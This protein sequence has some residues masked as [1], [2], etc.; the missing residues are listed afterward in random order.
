MQIYLPYKN[1]TQSIKVL[2][3]DDLIKQRENLEEMLSLIL[4]EMELITIN[5]SKKEYEKFLSI[6]ENPLFVYWW[7]QGKPFCSYLLKYLEGCNF[8]LFN[9]GKIYKKY[10]LFKKIIKDNKTKFNNARPQ[11]PKRL[12]DGYRVILLCVREDYYLNKFNKTYRT[13][14]TTIK[15]L[16]ENEERFKFA[17]FLKLEKGV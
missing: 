3:E 11:I 5:K 2:H 15:L 12:T 1:F 13:N 4:F 7:N 6:K 9:K 16:R 10:S 14:K 17:K 8:E